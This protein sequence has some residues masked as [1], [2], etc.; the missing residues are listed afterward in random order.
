MPD[1][2]DDIEETTTEADSKPTITIAELDGDTGESTD[3]PTIT[4]AEKG[5]GA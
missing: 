1:Q 5:G 2:T 4:I 3:K